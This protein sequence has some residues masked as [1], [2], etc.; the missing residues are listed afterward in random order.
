MT[1]K[2]G[3]ATGIT[4]YIFRFRFS[5]DTSDRY[6]NGGDNVKKTVLAICARD[7]AYL[8]RLA[9]YLGR[10]K[11]D[12]PDIRFFSERERYLSEDAEGIFGAVLLEESF[13]PEEPHGSTRYILLNE[14]MVPEEWKGF[15]TIF[16]YQSA[17]NLLRELLSQTAEFGEKSV[18]TGGK[19]L[20]AVY[21]PHQHDLQMAFSL[22][23]AEILSR[24]RRTLYLNFM[25]CA[26]FEQQFQETY[27]GDLGDL[28]YYVKT[29]EERLF[30]KLNSMTYR[31]GEVDYI[32]PALNPENL[33]EAGSEDYE[34]FLQY[35]TD[36]TD[37][38]V[39]V[40]DFGEI[41]PGFAELLSRC[42][43]I[44]CPMQDGGMNEARKQQ[45]LSY[46]RMDEGTDLAERVRFFQLIDL[47][48]PAE[49]LLE[50]KERIFYGESG[51]LLRE[52]IM[53]NGGEDG[54]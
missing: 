37:Y 22:G 25:D 7:S 12:H 8:R 44:F 2:E 40:L 31:I 50:A 19:E 46:L 23:M 14:G 43:R 15:P 10:Q 11:R 34:A 32:P 54:A 51:E 6:R 28:L 4:G 21:S 39:I 24:K 41:L 5:L 13:F 30:G 18:Y 16:K 42:D 36:K 47:L 20:I 35:L 33:H 17:D 38:E 53:E 45:F 48:K 3:M 1:A 29:G 9:E 27:R 49:N 26:G 52:M